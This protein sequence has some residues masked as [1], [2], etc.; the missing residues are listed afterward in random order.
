MG[1]FTSRLYIDQLDSP[2]F[3]RTGLAGTVNVFASQ[4]ALGA[5]DNYTRVE[6]ELST[7]LSSGK[8]ALQLIRHSPRCTG[9]RRK[10]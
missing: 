3:S 9:S 10:G 1:A 6:G 4:K 5:S 7:A 2:I 8:N